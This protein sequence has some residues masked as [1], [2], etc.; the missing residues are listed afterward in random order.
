MSADLSDCRSRDLASS[1]PVAAPQ[2]SLRMESRLGRSPHFYGRCRQPAYAA[3]GDSL[4][5]FCQVQPVGH[6]SRAFLSALCACTP[7]AFSSIKNTRRLSGGGA[8]C[9]SSYLAAF[10]AADV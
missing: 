4:Y 6:T 8:L 2:L 3:M 7:C 10:D 9:I 5:S 1:N